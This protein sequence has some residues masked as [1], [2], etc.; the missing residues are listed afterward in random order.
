MTIYF[1]AC[2]H[3]CLVL[4][5]EAETEL[6]LTKESDLVRV[7]QVLDL[8]NNDLVACTVY[9]IKDNSKLK[10]F[11]VIDSAQVCTIMRQL[12]KRHPNYL[13]YTVFTF[14]K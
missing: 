2:R 3:L 8:T 7:G 11:M 4:R 14:L 1:C 12:L 5:G 13:P 10:R 9:T 6:P